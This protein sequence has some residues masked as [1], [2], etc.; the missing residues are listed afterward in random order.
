M[1]YGLWRNARLINVDIHVSKMAQVLS[2]QRTHIFQQRNP[3]LPQPRA[4][5]ARL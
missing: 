4:G 5:M 3:P 1:D 2:D